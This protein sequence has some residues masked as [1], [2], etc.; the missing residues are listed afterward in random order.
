MISVAMASYNG[1]EYIR[2]QLDSILENLGEQDEVVISDDGSSDGTVSIIRSY[3][4]RDPRIR[5]LEGP[6]EGI[7]AN[8]EL[9]IRKCKGDYIFLS[10]QDDIWFPEKVK[11]VIDAFNKGAT[12]VMHDAKVYN[13]DLTSVIMPSFFEYRGCRSG[14]FANIVKNRYI[15]CCMAFRRSLVS[16]MLPIPRNI[17]MHDQWIGLVADLRKEQVTL[18][19]EP[20]LKYR[21]HAGTGSDFSHN[22]LPV[23]V[24]NRLVLL[25][26]LKKAGKRIHGK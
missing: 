20:L 16:H 8:F 2:P 18:L 10:D 24:K 3:M 7:I 25:R 13:E 5:F 11:K 26:E 22:T 17:Q 4:E 15:G 6:K 9:A 23:M 14:A 1:A 19:H 21:R 12:L